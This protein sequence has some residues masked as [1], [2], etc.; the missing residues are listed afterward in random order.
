MS[1]PLSAEELVEAVSSLQAERNELFALLQDVAGSVLDPA[2]HG[3]CVAYLKAAT[4]D[5]IRRR[6]RT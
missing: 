1:S 6:V 5:E 2:P 3:L 4:L